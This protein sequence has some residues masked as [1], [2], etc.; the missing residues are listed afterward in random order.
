MDTS[1]LIGLNGGQDATYWEILSE[2]ERGTTKYWPAIVDGEERPYSSFAS[3]DEWHAARVERE[4]M[5]VR[6][7]VAGNPIAAESAL[8]E[9]GYRCLATAPNTLEIYI[10][11]E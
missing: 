7:L 10:E 6:L 5:T 8:K 1:D 9:Q 4:R 3:I 11:A 2:I